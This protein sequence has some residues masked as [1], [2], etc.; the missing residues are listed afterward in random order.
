MNSS[1]SDFPV[2]HLL[3]EFAQ[4]HVHGVDDA[5]QPSHPLPSPS[6]LAFNLSQHPCLF[7]WVGSGHQAAKV[8]ELEL[9]HQSFQWIFRIDFLYNWLV[10][11]LCVSG[12][13]DGKVSA[14]I[15]GDPDSIHGSRCSS[16]EGHDNPRQYSCLENSMGRGAWRAIVHG[17]TTSWTGLSN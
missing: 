17:V 2:L 6:P 8:L 7:Q 5:F 16:G 12:G 4:T 13:P 14:C 1:T 11:S 3:P 10:W 9:Q 15:A